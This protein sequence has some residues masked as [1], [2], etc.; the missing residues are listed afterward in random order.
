MRVL[1]T[2]CLLLIMAG[3]ISAL[4]VKFDGDFRTRFYSFINK[5]MD[6]TRNADYWSV[7]SRLR[8]GIELEV[9][10]T[11]TV[12]Y[13]LEVGNLPWG[14]LAV[15]GGLGA[16]KWNL[17]TKNMYL[18][19]KDVFWHGK[20]GIFG[21]KTPLGSE[22]DDDLMGLKITFTQPIFEIDV[23]VSKLFNGTNNSISNVN[24]DNDYFEVESWTDTY[25]YF[26]NGQIKLAPIN[27]QVYFMRVVD[28]R[29]AFKYSLNWIGTYDTLKID[30]LKI[31]L[32]FSY[33]MGT[34]DN[35][36]TTIGVSA[37]HL[38]GKA[39]FEFF[40]FLKIF[41]R[42]NMTTGN[43]TNQNGIEQYQVVGNHGNFKSDLGILFGGGPFSQQSYFDYRVVSADSRKNLTRGAIRF[44]DPG[45]FVIEFGAEA[46][47][48]DI[49][50]QSKFVAGIAQT[51]VA[52]GTN[53]ATLLGIEFDLHN[54]FKL[55]KNVYFFLSGAI[56]IP[57][58]ALTP[59]YNMN[60]STI[61]L[62]TDMAFKVDGKIEIE[63]K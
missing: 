32:G 50:L 63:F 7:D 27:A 10:P 58:T 19:Y 51:T 54:R 55:D 40:N 39:E 53:N 42:V 11:F 41:A 28:D 15:G 2:L 16:D 56:L 60:H 52:V 23:M 37:F 62:G 9:T 8:L 61:N 1:H 12:Y 43:D 44:D 4:D 26:V 14:E 6:F 17:E 34:V 35:L 59:V 57:G 13:K 3:S 36:G 24:D 45:L 38:Y 22:L 18:D 5:D 29:F 33:N 25:L 49:G 30:P 46:N 31:D 21:F 47:I 20:L 48:K